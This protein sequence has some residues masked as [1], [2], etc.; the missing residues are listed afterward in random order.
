MIN[1]PV[2][3]LW[4]A[5]II[6]GS[7]QLHLPGSPLSLCSFWTLSLNSCPRAW[8]FCLYSSNL[9]A[10]KPE[11]IFEMAR[12]LEAPLMHC[13]GW[14]PLLGSLPLRELIHCPGCQ[15]LV[16]TDNLQICICL[17][18][19]PLPQSLRVMYLTA[20]WHLLYVSWTPHSIG[21]NPFLP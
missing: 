6:V 7:M 11:Y 16:L 2:L 8:S 15:Y 17:L 10:L 21:S 20:T 5:V 14:A 1:I 12:R 18:P 13:L 3:F 4:V 19:W 9:L